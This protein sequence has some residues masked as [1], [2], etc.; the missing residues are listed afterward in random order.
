M[1]TF[2]QM[3]VPHALAAKMAL[4][5]QRVGLWKGDPF[6]PPQDFSFLDPV[7]VQKIAKQMAN[8]IGLGDLVFIVSYA[9]QGAN[10]AGHVE[11]RH[12]QPDVFIEIDNSLECPESVLAVLAHEIAHKFLHRRGVILSNEQ[13][14]EELTDLAT[15]FMGFGRLSLNGCEAGREKSRLHEG[16]YVDA[17][18]K[19]KVGYLG[20]KVF[21]EAYFLHSLASGLSQSQWRDGLNS[22]AL[23]SVMQAELEH[24]GVLAL[25][26]ARLSTFLPSSRPKWHKDFVLLGGLVKQVL[27]QVAETLHSFHQSEASLR[28][29]AGDLDLDSRRTLLQS[30]EFVAEVAEWERRTEFNAEAEGASSFFKAIDWKFLSRSDL[31]RSSKFLLACPRCEADLRVS[32]TAEQKTLR[33]PKCTL[34]FEFA[35][36]IHHVTE[37]KANTTAQEVKPPTSKGGWLRRILPSP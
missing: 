36:P 20:M 25:N 34:E 13:E 2:E 24:E 17:T 28:R 14:N 8:S 16:R 11:L 33:C 7:A 9:K 29:R 19:A 27:R 4:L 35:G 30:I 22:Q 5:E 12:G 21:A 32:N 37:A 15:I 18:N 1:D 23:Q 26:S 31:A 6:V 3:K 10:V